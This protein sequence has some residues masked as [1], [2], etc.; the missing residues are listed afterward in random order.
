MKKI[1][2]FNCLTQ[3]E[4][5]SS[6][7]PRRDFLRRICLIGA[8]GYFMPSLTAEANSFGS[9]DYRYQIAVC[10]WM[11]LKRQKLGAFALAKE[12][13]ADGIQLDMGGLG[14]RD[15]FDSKL[16]D[17]EN[18]KQFLE[19]SKSQ[20]IAISSI[21]MSGFY[22][23]SFA[24]RPTVPQMVDD[25]L[26]TMERMDIEI[27]YLPLGVDSDFS[28]EPGLREKVIQRLK[29]AG[30]KAQ[31]MNKVIAVETA[32]EAKEELAF[33]KEIDSPAIKSSFNFANAIK[34]GKVVEKELK[35]LGKEN[36]AQIHCSDTDGVWI[37]NNP[38]LDMPKIKQTLDA[39]GWSGWLI[40]ERS[41]DVN[42]VRN[43]KGNYGANARYMKDVFQP[44]A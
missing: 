19:E 38:K 22:G 18:V 5:L 32:L 3:T 26:A 20:N 8:A 29:E 24:N 36:I 13:G 27:A 4:I 12:I 9:N 6:S 37:E 31:E 44:V 28:K 43:V 34:N 42:D 23:Q 40:I 7:N 35:I 25:T 1:N 14:D 17:P 21:A 10:D 2:P 11:I 41:R 39:M 33:L 16:N 15:T 30:A